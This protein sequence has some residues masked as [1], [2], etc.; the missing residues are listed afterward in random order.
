MLYNQI[1]FHHFI[2]SF[3]KAGRDIFSYDGYQALF[4]YLESVDD[5]VEFDIVD[6]ACSYNELSYD[7]VI[8]VYQLDEDAT[9]EDII[10]YLNEHTFVVYVGPES[11]LFAEF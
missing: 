6:I 3:K 8:Q 11:V 10:E 5:W 4:N 1:N 7:E 2:D 9:P